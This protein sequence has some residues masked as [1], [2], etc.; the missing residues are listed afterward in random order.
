MGVLK[1]YVCLLHGEFE[2]DLP[3]CPSFGCDSS[4]VQQEFRTPPKIGSAATRRFDAGMRQTALAYRLSD[5]RSCREGECARPPYESQYGCEVLYGEAVARKLG[6][7]FTGLSAAAQANARLGDLP[8][9]N[10]MRQ[11]ATEAGLTGITQSGVPPSFHTVR[12]G[13][14]EKSAAAAARVLPRGWT[15]REE[16]LTP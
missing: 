1:E 4:L 13:A 11:A 9:N 6:Q 10:G 8:A 14:D 5:L 2:R 15:A 3:I 12:H 7:D 16:K